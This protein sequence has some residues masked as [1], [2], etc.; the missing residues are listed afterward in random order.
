MARVRG[1]GLALK[2]LQ[3]FLRGVEFLCAA[4]ILAIFS[5]FLATLNNHG[6]AISSHDRAV[7]GI[8]GAAVLYTLLGLLLLC[9]VAGHPFTSA[10]AIILDIAFLGAFIYVAYENRNGARS[11]SGNVD[12]V[13]GSGDADT[14]NRVSNSSGS[15]ILPSF[16]QAC[17]LQTACFAVAIVAM[18]TPSVP[19]ELK[20]ILTC[21]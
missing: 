15:T 2:S 16:K 21:A 6:L 17:Q 19:S 4:L 20:C 14:G 18:Y 13:F 9:F 12:T 3:W 1:A 10:I 8:S 7:E 5:Y 11:C